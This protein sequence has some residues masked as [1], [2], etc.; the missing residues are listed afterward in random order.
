LPAG[1]LLAPQVGL[2]SEGE[3][4]GGGAGQATT[5]SGFAERLPLPP[6]PYLDAMPWMNFG[7]ES[8]GPRVGTLLPP[9]FV[10]PAT[11]KD[12]AYTN[13]DTLNPRQMLAGTA[14]N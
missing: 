10:A 8:K 4:D 5:A 12:F 13:H 14:R 1:V 3:F 2:A 7:S 6:I 11:T 9:N